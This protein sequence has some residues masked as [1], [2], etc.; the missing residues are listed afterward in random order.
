MTVVAAAVVSVER[1]IVELYFTE[2][3]E[4]TVVAVVAA[5]A[6]DVGFEAIA[7]RSVENYQ[8]H[9]ALHHQK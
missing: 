1:L 3:I 7:G 8:I 6:V 4:D 9:L 2:S 5:T